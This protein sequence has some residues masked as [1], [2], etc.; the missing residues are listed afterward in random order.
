MTDASAKMPAP[1]DLTRLERT[2]ADLMVRITALQHGLD[3]SSSSPENTG[4][5]HERDHALRSEHEHMVALRSALK[6]LG[7]RMAML[8]MQ[9]EGA[10]SPIPALVQ[11]AGKTPPA[12][13]TEMDITGA[14]IAQ[15]IH[16]LLAENDTQ[17]PA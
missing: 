1:S 16:A 13:N 17:H 12:S 9:Q 7:A 4:S 14:S 8:T 5:G 6:D 2:I 10:H 11:E 15:R 3:N